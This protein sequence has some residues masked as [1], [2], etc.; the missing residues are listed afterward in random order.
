[1]MILAAVV[2]FAAATHSYPRPYLRQSGPPVTLVVSESVSLDGAMIAGCRAAPV[3]V[4]EYADFECP[5]CG[6]FARD[7]LPVIRRRYLDNCRVL[8]AFRHLPV[9]ATHPFA[10]DAAEAAAC[11]ATE[12]RFWAMHD[13]LYDEQDRLDP[14]GLTEKARRIGLDET[15]FKACMDLDVMLSQIRLDAGEG[16]TLGASGTPTLL[17]GTVDESGAVRVTRRVG[18]A[19][20]VRE[21]EEILDDLLR[22]ARTP[23]IE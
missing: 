13:L 18:G 14:I 15:A 3:A 17:V 1:M 20:N 10:L 22:E 2:L 11:A 16:V 12:D 9:A 5:A 19:L 6:V 21:L 8:L 23:G 4:V 7:V